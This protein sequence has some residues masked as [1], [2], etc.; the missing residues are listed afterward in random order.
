MAR[1]HRTDKRTVRF[2]TAIIFVIIAVLGVFAYL[3]MSDRDE[4][5]DPRLPLA[6]CLTEKGAKFYGAY[7]CPHCAAQK[8]LFGKAMSKVTYIEC[9]IPGDS[10]AQTQ[11]CKDAGISGYPTWVFANGT[12]ASGEVS[13]VSLAERTGCPYPGAQTE[14]TPPS[15]NTN[16]NTNTNVN[17]NAGTNVNVSVDAAKKP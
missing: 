6:Q 9:A 2:R 8:K 14:E 7:W 10:S 13:L 5:P 16:E 3:R 11:P 17:V 1:Y 4:G 15:T 12:R